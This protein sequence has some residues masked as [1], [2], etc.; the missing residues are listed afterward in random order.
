MVNDS[1]PPS[2]WRGQNSVQVN[3][4]STFG[5]AI[6]I[7]E[8]R[9]QMCSAPGS[10]RC[11]PPGPAGIVS[12]LYPCS[13]KSWPTLK[14][15]RNWTAARVALNAPSVPRITGASAVAGPSAVS[16]YM[17]PVAGSSPV[18]RCPKWIFT[19][20]ALSA[21]SSRARFSSARLI[22]LIAR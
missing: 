1:S 9:G 3:E 6:I 10:S 11:P 12:S 4:P 19:P 14:P 18:S 22:E 16:K 8:P 20:G 15:S 2:P 13:R 21:Q 7:A 17:I 5:S